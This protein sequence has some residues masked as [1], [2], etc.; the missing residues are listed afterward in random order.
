MLIECLKVQ[1]SK[2]ITV[3]ARKHLGANSLDLT[4]PTDLRKSLD[5]APGD[6]FLVSNEPRGK[7]VVISYRRIFH[8]E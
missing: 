6:V 8:R 4:I 1:M 5:I 3:K 7:E 2:T